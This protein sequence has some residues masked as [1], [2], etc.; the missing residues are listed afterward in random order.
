MLLR[1]RLRSIYPKSYH[2]Q[3]ILE[4]PTRSCPFRAGC[5]V[6]HPQTQITA[7]LSAV[8]GGDAQAAELLWRLVYDELHRIAKARM[9]REN[10]RGDLQTTVLMQEVYL[11]LVGRN[12][13][14]IPRD[15]RHFFSAAANAMRQF[16]V[17]DARTRGRQKRGGGRRAMELMDEAA[18]LDSHPA[19]VLALDEALSKLRAKDS[20]KAEIIQLRYFTGLSVD[21]T[22]EMLGL[23]PRTVDKEWR[24]AKAWLHRELS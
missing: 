3:T 23:S 19:D 5:S 17:D 6:S 11:R 13:A 12:G 15:R 4:T 16:L 14:A 10:R 18:T 24:F 9:A 2:A 21:E 20:R 7:L 1:N 8:S 22:A